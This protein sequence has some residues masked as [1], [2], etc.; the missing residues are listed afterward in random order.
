MRVSYDHEMRRRLPHLDNLLR[1]HPGR[2]LAILVLDGEANEISK[3]RGRVQLDAD[4]AAELSKTELIEEFLAVRPLRS[5]LW[6]K[7]PANER[8]K[9]TRLKRD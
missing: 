6:C 5:A 7:D 8:S 4:K 3:R 2:F 1:G 9:L